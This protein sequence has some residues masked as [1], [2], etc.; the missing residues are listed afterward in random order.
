VPSLH[1]VN[2]I[3][4]TGTAKCRRHCEAITF[5]GARW[6]GTGYPLTSKERARKVPGSLFVC[7][8]AISGKRLATT[9][10]ERERQ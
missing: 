2:A 6:R 10:A 7:T 4:T 3:N 9:P 8:P 5:S 1:P